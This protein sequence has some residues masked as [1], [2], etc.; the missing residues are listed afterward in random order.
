MADAIIE[1]SPKKLVVDPISK[2]DVETLIKEALKNYTPSDENYFELPTPES[3][4]DA[5]YL[6]EEQVEYIY[7]NLKK[8]KIVQYDG[9]YFK[10]ASFIMSKDG[11]YEITIVLSIYF[12][13]GAINSFLQ[14]HIYYSNEKYNL[15]IDEL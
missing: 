5:L 13:E 12:E 14:W 7:E 2:K 8:G 9:G 6:T 10:P 1:N 4:D 15:V 3:V 11:Q